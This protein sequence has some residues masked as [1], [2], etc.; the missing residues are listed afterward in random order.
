[1]G[2][3]S[4]AE[5]NKIRESAGLQPLAP[6]GVFK[7]KIVTV[8]KEKIIRPPPIIK[9][10]E[11]VKVVKQVEIRR[12]IGRPKKQPI[13][14]NTDKAKHQ[15]FLSELLNG[16]AEK[17]IKKV[18]NKALD[19]E[20]KDQMACIKMCVERVLPMSYFEK[21]KESGSNKGVSITIMG[22]GQSVIQKDVQN[23]DEDDDDPLLL[24]GVEINDDDDSMNDD[25]V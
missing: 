17:L 12:P 19:D 24:E 7:P 11:K 15:L 8:V 1:M 22:V 4:I 20:D 18:I 23:E 5:V 25:G 21:A 9:V 3:R 14:A 10:V 16:N 2:R 6:K 13:V